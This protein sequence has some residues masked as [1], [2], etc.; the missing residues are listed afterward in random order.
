MHREVES[1]RNQHP[2]AL[3]SDMSNGLQRT[4]GRP[5][6]GHAGG[7]VIVRLTTAMLAAPLGSEDG[8]VS[9][10]SCASIKLPVTP[11]LRA[12]AGDAAYIEGNH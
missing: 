5:L 7:L 8:R 3:N 4:N 12:G 9:A 10:F 11:W 1:I 6:L 2:N